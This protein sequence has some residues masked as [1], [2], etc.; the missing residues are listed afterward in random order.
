M[1]T[2]PQRLKGFE[3]GYKTGRAATYQREPIPFRIVAP[4]T[5]AESAEAEGFAVGF[6][7]GVLRSNGERLS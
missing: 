3:K 1:Y 2:I 5:A 7:D 6:T 4:S